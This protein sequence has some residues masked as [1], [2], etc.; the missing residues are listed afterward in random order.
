VLPL[1]TP[2]VEEA[3]DLENLGQYD[4][5]R[6]FTERAQAALPAFTL[7]RENAGAVAQ[8][9]QRL[10]GIPLAIELAAARAS[11]LSVAQIAQRLEDSFQILTFGC[12]TALAPPADLAGVDGLEL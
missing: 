4:A 1:S 6:L 5:V 11:I 12:R 3:I 8:I 9:C 10:D 2:D 7:T